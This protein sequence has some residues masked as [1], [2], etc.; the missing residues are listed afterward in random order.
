MKKIISNEPLLYITQPKSEK[1]KSYMQSEFMTESNEVQHPAKKDGIKLEND[2]EM[3]SFK[4]LSLEEKINYL[5]SIPSGLFQLK[6]KFTTKENTYYG[7]VLDK[8]ETTVDIIHSGR[9]K[10]TVNIADLESIN[11]IGL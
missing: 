10:V 11:L 1:P 3:M 6:C 8:D 7:T 4:H 9:Q 5:V 2:A